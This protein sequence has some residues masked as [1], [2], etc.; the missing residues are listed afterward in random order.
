MKP[1]KRKVRSEV[2]SR[3]AKKLGLTVDQLTMQVKGR[4]G[5][6]GSSRKVFKYAQSVLNGTHN[7]V[8]RKPPFRRAPDGIPY[9]GGHV[10]A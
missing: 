2:I 4:L 1:S 8:E 9:M 7:T 5:E 3:A 6:K 10:S